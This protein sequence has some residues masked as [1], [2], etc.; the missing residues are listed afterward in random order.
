MKCVL[1]RY[2]E[3]GPFV[4]LLDVPG[5]P[6]QIVIVFDTGNEHKRVRMPREGVE[7][8]PPSPG[9][10]VIEGPLRVEWMSPDEYNK[11]Y[12]EFE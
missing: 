3:S 7:A 11:Y 4:E 10:I 8:E 12:D 9:D 2:L 5:D 1:K 6:D